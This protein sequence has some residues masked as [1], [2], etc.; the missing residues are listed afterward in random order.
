MKKERRIRLHALRQGDEVFYDSRWWQVGKPLEID[1]ALGHER[2][3]VRRRFE[4]KRG[5]KTTELSGHKDSVV[6]IMRSAPIKD[7]DG[8]TDKS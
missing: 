1:V 2:A 7:K 5:S 6:R 8:G 4:L 3:D